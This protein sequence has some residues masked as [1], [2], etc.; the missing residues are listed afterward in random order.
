MGDNT[1]NKTSTMTLQLHEALNEVD[2]RRNKIL[3]VCFYSMNLR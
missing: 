1:N 2:Q 3:H